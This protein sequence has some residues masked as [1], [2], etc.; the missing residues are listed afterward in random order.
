MAVLRSLFSLVL[1][2]GM[3][4]A[5]FVW[6]KRRGSVP[7]VA[8]RRMRVVERLA[9]DTRRSILLIEVDGRELLVGVGN[10]TLSP[11]QTL[12]RGGETDA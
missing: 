8:N 1:V 4:V 7:G 5:V 10:D 3:M 9:V 6:L 2:I 11:L 12:E